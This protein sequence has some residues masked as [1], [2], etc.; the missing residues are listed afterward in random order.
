[1][2]RITFRHS[3]IVDILRKRLNI[4]ICGKK[5]NMQMDIMFSCFAFGMRFKMLTMCQRPNSQRSYQQL[6]S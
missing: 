5:E 4:F 3:N 1:V 6:P 2:G